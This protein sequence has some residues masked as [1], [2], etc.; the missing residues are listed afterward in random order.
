MKINAP[1]S[2]VKELDMLLHFGAD[3]LYCGFTPPGW[4]TRFGTQ[5]WVNRRSPVQANLPAWEDL[6]EIV[7]TAHRAALK[8]NI[9]LNAAFYPPAGLR[10]L[11]KLAHRLAADARVDGL[12]VSD[13]N[14]LQQLGG[15]QLPVR[16]H[17]SSLGSCFNSR[18]VEFYRA[19]GVDRVIL[20]RQLTLSE[21]QRLVSGAAGGMEFEI[22]AVNDGCY[23]EEGF[24]QTSHALGPFCHS[25]WTPEPCGPSPG[26]GAGGF[27][28]AAEISALQRY[29]WFQ[30]NCGCSHQADGL[31]NG[32]CSLCWFGH[33]RDWGI[34]VVKIVGREA[35]FMRK[36]RS[37]QLVK[38]VLDEVQSGA[39]PEAVAALA[40]SLRNTPEYC[41][42]G[43]MCYFRED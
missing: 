39:D 38:A 11:V 31:P 25:R 5:W 2:S 23:F 16:L 42:S 4:E 33:F 8:V 7:E 28:L 41:D 18:S 21:I 12:I 30:N 22:F 1:V 6:L 27:D 26:G 29:L 34:D 10:Y 19:M 13:F 32:P 14:L 37:L 43:Y 35:S 20:P 3:E 36:M 24:C 9:T 15:E 40:R 17:L